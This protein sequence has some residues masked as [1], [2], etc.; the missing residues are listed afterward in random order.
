MRYIDADKLMEII[1][2]RDYRITSGSEIV[3]DYG[4]HFDNGM[5]TD[6][7]QQIIDEM[8]VTDV[9]S[10]KHGKWEFIND[11]QS[12]CTCCNAE[13]YVDHENEFAYCPNCGAD[14]REK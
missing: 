3:D 2:E 9:E 4:L 8:P 14:M 13:E 10:I 1:R 5:Y 6:E 11:Y 12:R 7:I